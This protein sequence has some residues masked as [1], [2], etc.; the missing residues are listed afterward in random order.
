MKLPLF[1][2]LQFRFVSPYKSTIEKHQLY[3][4]P[5]YDVDGNVIRLACDQCNLDFSTK[6]YL[7][8]HIHK[9]HRSKTVRMWFVFVN[10][11]ILHNI[12][13]TVYKFILDLFF[14]NV[15]KCIEKNQNDVMI[16]NCYIITLIKKK[17]KIY[18]LKY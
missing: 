5:V 13:A 18:I 4:H 3:Y 11:K 6:I 7:N 12:Q 2:F 16:T 9:N 1:P 8:K 15:C 17:K 14:E 10:H